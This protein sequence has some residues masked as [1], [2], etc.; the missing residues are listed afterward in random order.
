M[1][2]KNLLRKKQPESPKVEQLKTQDE[3]MVDKV[4]E[5]VLNLV[6]YSEACKNNPVLVE[7]SFSITKDGVDQGVPIHK[8]GEAIYRTIEVYDGESSY[9]FISQVP[10]N[11]NGEEGVF[12]IKHAAGVYWSK[13]ANPNFPISCL[14]SPDEYFCGIFIPNSKTESDINSFPFT[15]N[16]LMYLVEMKDG[17]IGTRGNLED[18]SRVDGISTVEV[19][20]SGKAEKESEKA[21]E[22]SIDSKKVKDES[23]SGSGSFSPS[24][25]M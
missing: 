2:I 20:K 12:L 19:V 8:Y 17:K 9:D 7:A 22:K 14:K 10:G 24:P 5:G 4:Y 23:R 3:I 13:R 25:Q 18:L 16:D 21:D 15:L 6:K 1:N 11:F